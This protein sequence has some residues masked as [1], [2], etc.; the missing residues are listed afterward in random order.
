M[1]GNL[2]QE[3]NTLWMI[4]L[5]L[6][7][8][9]ATRKRWW[10]PVRV[11]LLTPLV[12]VFTPLSIGVIINIET[13]GWCVIS[14]IAAQLLIILIANRKRW[15]WQ[16]RAVLISLVAISMIGLPGYKL[17]QIDKERELILAKRAA[18]EKDEKEAYAYFRKKCAED[19]GRFIYKA[20]TEPQESVLMMK[21]RR[22]PTEQEL[23]DQ[24]WMG[25]PYG[26]ARTVN[27][28][29]LLSLLSQVMT[30]KDG[31]KLP[32][33][34]F[35]EIYDM[36][37]PD[38]PLWRYYLKDGYVFSP[39]NDEYHRKEPAE[40]IQ[41]RYGFTWD[42]LSS[43]EDRHYWVAKSRLRIVDLQAK[44]VIAERI[45]YAISI[46]KWSR[47]ATSRGVSSNWDFCPEKQDITDMRWVR[48]VLHN[49]P[50]N[51]K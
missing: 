5:L 30:T 46:G 11:L 45:G 42:D 38:Q 50:F 44:E 20:V 14:I 37:H 36:D 23:N 18:H 6:I 19:S 25:D 32:W 34:S 28:P 27:R 29:E 2:T 8:F 3:V 15:L 13:S 47:L 9:I 24:F 35:V 31:H 10:I 41:S 17:Y 21:P 51:E 33:F 4:L 49:I 43:P 22:K 12:I 1:V 39:N 40:N 16:V 48:S 26:W 7:I